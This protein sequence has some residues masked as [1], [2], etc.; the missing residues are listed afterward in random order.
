MYFLLH[1]LDLEHTFSFKYLPIYL[2][3]LVENF[4]VC[5]HWL[6]SSFL[7]FK[8]LNSTS[9]R[10]L[11]PPNHWHCFSHVHQWPWNSHS[12]FLVLT[13]AD[14]IC[15]ASLPETIH[16]VSIPSQSLSLVVFFFK[17]SKPLNNRMCQHYVFIPLLY[18]LYTFLVSPSSSVSSNIIYAHGCLIITPILIS[19][20]KFMIFTHTHT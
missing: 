18:C 9:V 5:V 6:F 4:K 12:H 7:F 8:F 13:V 20:L 2:S 19:F 10:C 15:L 1:I 17:S 16:L 3:F 11:I 14:K